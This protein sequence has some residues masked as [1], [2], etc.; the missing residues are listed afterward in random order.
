MVPPPRGRWT[1]LAPCLLGLFAHLVDR[2]AR[3]DELFDREFFLLLA[4]SD[5][6]LGGDG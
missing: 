2:L 5:V 4:G 3:L 1:S 6:E